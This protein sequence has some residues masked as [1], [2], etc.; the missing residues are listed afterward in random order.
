VLEDVAD[1]S[2]C[3]LEQIIQACQVQVLPASDRTY[4]RHVQSCAP[5]IRHVARLWS[6]E[7]EA[8]GQIR[9]VPA[10]DGK[11]GD[12]AFRTPLIDACCSV[13]AA[14][15]HADFLTEGTRFGVASLG[16]L[17]WYADLPSDAYLWSHATLQTHTS[18]GAEVLRG[19]VQVWDEAQQ[20]IWEAGDVCLR[21]FGVSQSRV[22]R[23]AAVPTDPSSPEPAATSVVPDLLQ[24]LCAAPVQERAAR[25][26]AYLQGQL[27]HT[28]GLPA[29]RIDVEQPLTNL[30][31]DSLMALEIK[32]RVEGELGAEIPIVNLLEGPT[33]TRLADQLLQQLAQRP[34]GPPVPLPAPEEAGDIV[35]EEAARLLQQLEG[36]PDDE[37]DALMQRMLAHEGRDP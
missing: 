14:V 33:I 23:P 37:V 1:R 32:S 7:H 12:A 21:R 35:G 17:R 22:S 3:P 36:L 24:S 4:Q 30:G 15:R 6:G 9:F 27:A 31:I 18:N 16:Q 26:Q 11:D 28:L 2:R 34:A 25:I 8:L 13:M 10:A 29:S 19:S 20:L 5:A